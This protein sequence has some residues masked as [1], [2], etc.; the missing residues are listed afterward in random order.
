MERFFA[1]EDWQNYG[2]LVHALK[3]TS[4]MIGASALSEHAARMEKAAEEGDG[5]TIGAEHAALLAEYA[6]VLQAVRALLPETETA[7]AGDG[8]ALEFMPDDG[9]L[10]FAPEG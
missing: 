1:A 4:K 7:P 8:E 10:E 5:R 3:S 9:V 2:V 6:A